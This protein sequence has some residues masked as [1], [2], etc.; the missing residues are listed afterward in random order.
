MI[1]G[2]GIP[3][4]SDWPHPAQNRANDNAS[5]R[6]RYPFTVRWFYP[7][8]FPCDNLLHSDLLAPAPSTLLAAGQRDTVRLAADA[9]RM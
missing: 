3:V 6:A 7:V 4:G 9:E 5:P 1:V 2:A 8:I